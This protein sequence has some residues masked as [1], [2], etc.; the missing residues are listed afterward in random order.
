MTNV[1][2]DR[3]QK[4]E[5]W[6]SEDEEPYA[7]IS[8]TS[9]GTGF[10]G[11]T[12]IRELWL[13]ITELRLY[14][15]AQEKGPQKVEVWRSEN[16]ELYAIISGTSPCKGFPENT[17]LMELILYQPAQEKGPQKVEAWQSEDGELYE[18]KEEAEEAGKEFKLRASLS[19][20]VKDVWMSKKERVDFIDTVLDNAEAIVKAYEES[21]CQ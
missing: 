4:V 11:S 9:P 14:Q 8:G 18:T 7:I 1:E 6:Q 19:E 16:G 13:Y 17:Y 12:Y 5:V 15:P 3:N 2:R 20:I 21:R 10:P